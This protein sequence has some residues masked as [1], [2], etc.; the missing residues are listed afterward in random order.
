[1]SRWPSAYSPMR[2]RAV[3]LDQLAAG[4]DQRL[5]RDAVPQVRGAA[6]DVALDERDVG[7]ERGGD[8]GAGVARGATTQDHETSACRQ[9]LRAAPGR[10]RRRGSA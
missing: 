8:G 10:G 9:M 7:A 2:V 5:R 1:M 4:G 6:D 3:E